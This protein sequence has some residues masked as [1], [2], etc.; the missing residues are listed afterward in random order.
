MNFI[1][2][3]RLARQG[4]YITNK[5]WSVS[6]YI[7]ESCGD[8]FYDSGSKYS[9]FLPHMLNDDWEIYEERKSKTYNFQEAL[10]ALNEGKK[11]IRLNEYDPD[12]AFVK[13]G[14]VIKVSC[15]SWTYDSDEPVF[16]Y[17]DILASDWIIKEKE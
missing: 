1:E 7:Y 15:Y 17:D 6:V 9:F 3:L 13:E 12:K 10:L 16:S 11:I 8:I 5:Q 2:A 14:G 4:K